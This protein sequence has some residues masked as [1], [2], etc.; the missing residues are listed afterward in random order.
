MKT[1]RIYIATTIKSPHGKSGAIGFLIHNEPFVE[2][3]E[4]YAFLKEKNLTA[5]QANMTALFKAMINIKEKSHL[6]IYTNSIY[7]NLS[8]KSLGIWKNNNWKGSRGNEIANREAWEVLEKRLNG[9][10]IEVHV[11]ENHSYKKWMEAEL[12]RKDMEKCRV[13][14]R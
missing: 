12:L 8:L 10:E 3:E 2:G 9:H 6:V 13:K 11:N 14:K 4:R 7:M 5:N 1:V